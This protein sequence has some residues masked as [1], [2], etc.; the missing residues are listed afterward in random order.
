MS[1]STP[2]LPCPFCGSEDLCTDNARDFI[3][4][5]TCGTEGPWRLGFGVTR[6][7]EAWNQRAAVAEAVLRERERI[8][9]LLDSGWPADTSD[10]RWHRNFLAAVIR[11]TPAQTDTEGKTE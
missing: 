9:D 5:R 4:C 6:S 8:A 2:L 7:T 10:E 1:D 11:A 3:A